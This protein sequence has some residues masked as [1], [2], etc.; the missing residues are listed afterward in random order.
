MKEYINLRKK[1]DELFKAKEYQEALNK[2]LEAVSLNSEYYTGYVHLAKALLVQNR[3]DEAIEQCQKA[4]DIKKMYVYA[5]RIKGDA[6][7][8][9]AEMCLKSKNLAQYTE[10]YTQAEKCYNTAIEYNGGDYKIGKSCL[11]ELE[12]LKALFS[13]KHDE[14]V[15]DNSKL[16]TY[17]PQVADIDREFNLDP[18]GLDTVLTTLTEHGFNN[19]AGRAALVALT[20]LGFNNE[21]ATLTTLVEFGLNDAKVALEKLGF[22]DVVASLLRGD[23]QSVKI[24]SHNIGHGLQTFDDFVNKKAK[25]D[26]FDSHGSGNSTTDSLKKDESTQVTPEIIEHEYLSC[27]NLFIQQNKKC[28]QKGVT[29]NIDSNVNSELN[30][31]DLE[32][33]ILI[34]DTESINTIGNLGYII[35]ES[36]AIILVGDALRS[37]NPRVTISTLSKYLKGVSLNINDL[38]FDI[39]C[40]L[41]EGRSIQTIAQCLATIKIDQED[42]QNCFVQLGV[43]KE[44]VQYLGISNIDNL[45]SN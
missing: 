29:K 30:K 26:G 41:A 37:T 19:D 11:F 4:L 14:M 22:N 35:Q 40:A 31:Q 21:A 10:Q 15:Q 32:H 20:E 28:I 13:N 1:G 17:N 18:A 25:K 16:V 45:D 23:I 2:Y 7:K 43:D 27:E 42:I 38:S 9:K 3:Y 24:I 34:A 39:D 36:E 44:E 8:L 12:Q 6:Y 5:Y 33:A